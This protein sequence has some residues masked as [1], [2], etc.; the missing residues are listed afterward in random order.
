LTAIAPNESTIYAYS[1]D[2]H[3]LGLLTSL[4]AV[5]AAMPLAYV[6]VGLKVVFRRND[7]I[8]LWVSVMLSITYQTAKSCGEYV[9]PRKGRKCWGPVGTSIL[10]RDVF[11]TA[12]SKCEDYGERLR[13]LAAHRHSHTA[14][15][16]YRHRKRCFGY[17]ACMVPRGHG[18]GKG[19]GNT[20]ETFFW[21]ARKAT[22]DVAPEMLG[23]HTVSLPRNT[24]SDM[25][26][27]MRFGRTGVGDLV[28]LANSAHVGAYGLALGSAIRFLTTQIARA[29]GDTHDDV[30]LEPSMYGWLA[31]AMITTVSHRTGAPDKDGGNNEI[32]LKL[33]LNCLQHI[34][35]AP[36]YNDHRMRRLLCLGLPTMPYRKLTS[37]G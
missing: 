15:R 23:L 2:G 35:Y 5:G 34:P 8:P 13:G 33:N 14:H 28:A 24:C 31:T 12:F 30:Q 20:V 22:L 10:A 18:R 37:Q 9:S 27:P 29:R 6:S 11:E 26:L 21:R 32:E 19:Y 16:I 3:F 4:E 17:F 7:C 1:D 25:S 36:V